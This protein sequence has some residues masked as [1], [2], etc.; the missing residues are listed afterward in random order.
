[1]KKVIYE[2]TEENAIVIAT[3]LF[4]KFRANETFSNQDEFLNVDQVANLI[5][6]KK[7]SI[8]GLVKKN[9]IP[10]HKKGKLFFLKSEIL[11]WL[12]NGKKTTS[13]DIERSA[14][15]Y[16]LRNGIL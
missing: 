11:I 15:E 5:G 6:Y 9:Q 12:K 1:M 10:Y 2:V 16:L 3:L 13:Q 8:Y 14:S 7:T 4:E